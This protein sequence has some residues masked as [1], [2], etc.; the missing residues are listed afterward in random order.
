MLPL[1]RAKATFDVNDLTHVIDG[2]IEATKR[3]RWLWAPVSVHDN[4]NNY[5]LPRE[6]IGETAGRQSRAVG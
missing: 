3:R 4:S 5:F 2:G 1:E 6:K